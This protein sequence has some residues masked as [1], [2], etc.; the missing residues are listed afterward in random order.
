MSMTR[1]AATGARRKSST[2]KPMS[3]V[4][5][6]EMPRHH[7]WPWMR[8]AT[9]WRSGTRMAGRAPMASARRCSNDLVLTRN[10]IASIDRSC[11]PAYCARMAG[12]VNPLDVPMKEFTVQR[13]LDSG[14]VTVR[15]VDCAGTCR[16]RSP[17]ECAS[18]THFVFPYRGLYL[19]HVGGDLAVADA[20]HVL[21]F[22]QEQGYQVSHPVGG[23]DSSLVLSVS[24]E[25]LRELAP[26]DLVCAGETLRFK[27]Q[28]LRID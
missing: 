12:R 20:N 7:T 26:K 24:E 22:N 11:G 25:I 15:H 3:P 28:N 9:P 17:E 21:F 2:R 16:H 8:P 18:H 27:L 14:T 5:S 4:T 1:S 23:G 6:K 10:Q 19:R 13:L